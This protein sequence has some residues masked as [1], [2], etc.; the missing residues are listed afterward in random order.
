MTFLEVQL[1]RVTQSCLTVQ[2][3]S[4]R[5]EQI[6]SQM[7]TQEEKLVN[8]TRLVKLLQSYSDA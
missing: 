7:T 3:F 6:Q 2:G 4:E 8:T 5:I 1:E